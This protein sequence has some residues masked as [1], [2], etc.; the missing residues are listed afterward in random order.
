MNKQA[1]VQFMTTFIFT[2]LI[3]IFDLVVILLGGKSFAGS[4]QVKMLA[5]LGTGFGLIY[6]YSAI[7]KLLEINK[8]DIADMMAAAEAENAVGDGEEEPGEAE[9]EDEEEPEEEPEDGETDEEEQE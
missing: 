8:Q 3:L 7:R 6:D 2:G 9:E 4:S 5:A 1:K